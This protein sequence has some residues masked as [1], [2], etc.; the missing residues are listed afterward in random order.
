[1]RNTGKKT[2]ASAL[3]HRGGEPGRLGFAAI[4]QASTGE[5]N[6]NGPGA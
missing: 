6:T 5:L 4:I 2:D 3:G 1:L